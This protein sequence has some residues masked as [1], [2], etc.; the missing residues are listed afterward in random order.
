D[1][2][3]GE[4]LKRTGAQTGR[5]AGGALETLIDSIM[6][7]NPDV[8]ETIKSGRD[9]KGGKLKFLQRQVMKEAKGQADP[10]EAASL[11]SQKLS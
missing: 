11:L 6:A 10:Q 9:K 3:F 1:I 8:V 5:L 7:A 2:P 4:A